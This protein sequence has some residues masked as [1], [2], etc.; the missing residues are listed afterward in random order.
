MF[1][2]IIVSLMAC[3]KQMTIQ[4]EAGTAGSVVLLAEFPGNPEKVR[5]DSCRIENGSWTLR[6]PGLVLPARVWIQMEQETFSFIAD[7]YEGII[8]T[9]NF[10]DSLAVEGSRLEREF[11]MVEQV[12][13]ERYTQPTK[14]ILE[15]M[16]LLRSKPM[17]TKSDEKLLKAL[18]RNLERYREYEAHYL[19]KLVRAN[20]WNE[21]SLFILKERVEDPRTRQELWKTVHIKNKK[22]NIFQ[23]L[24][25]SLSQ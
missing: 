21:L 12:L 8:I 17:Q 25:S 24:L 23:L 18:E 15:E 9:G 20:P 3:R 22:S 6:G 13:A 14:E 7:A 2:F 11:E 4:G 5:L 10:P 19:E 1:C 16:K